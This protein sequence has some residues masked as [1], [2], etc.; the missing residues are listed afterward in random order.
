MPAES[1]LVIGAQNGVSEGG[2]IQLNAPGGAYTVAHFIDNYENRFRIMS[3]NNAGSSLTRLAINNTGNVGIGTE[4]PNAKLHVVAGSANAIEFEGGIKVSGTQA[5]RAAF[6][7]A[8]VP[9]TTQCIDCLTEFQYWELTLNHPQ[10]NNNPNCLIFITVVRNGFTGVN[11]IRYDNPT[12]RWK[13]RTD[14][15]LL[16]EFP[17]TFN[18]LIIGN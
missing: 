14:Y 5:N 4:G 6:N 16:G 8:P 9:L 11:S 10:C 18:V 2:Q 17:P 12:G 13:I 15:D 1:K 7:V 3:G